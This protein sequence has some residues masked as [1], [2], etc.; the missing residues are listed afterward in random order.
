MKT[1]NQMF[2]TVCGLL[3]ILT[4]GTV[5][6][7]CASDGGT[8]ANDTD[9]ASV[10][11]TEVL[12]GRDADRDTLPADLNFDGRKFSIFVADYQQ[13]FVGPEEET[14]DIVDDAVLDR[15]RAVE[16]RLN[17]DLEYFVDENCKWDTIYQILNKYIMAGDTTFDVYT[18]QQFGITSLLINGGFV[19][20]YD[21]KYLD[22][23]QP[24]WNNRYMD[25][26]AIGNNT[27]YFLV[28]DFF[29]SPLLNTHVVYFNKTMY[30]QLHEDPEE[31]YDLALNGTWTMD[32]MAQVAKDAYVDVNNNGKTDVDDQLGF[33]AYQAFSTVDPFMYMTDVEFTP[34]DKDGNLTF[35]LYDERC[36]DLTTSIVEFFHQAGV[37]T[38][39]A[40]GESALVKAV[41]T[42]GSAQFVGCYR[43]GQSVNF[44]DMKDDFGM[45]P[46]P[47]MDVNQ[48]HYN[49]LVADIATLGAVPITSQNQDIAGA[50]IEALSSESY[51]TMIPVWYEDA[52]KIKYS[53]DDKTSQIIDIIHDASYTDFMYAYSPNLSNV[54]CLMRDLVNGNNTNY[55]SFVEKYENKVLDNLEK[56]IATYEEQN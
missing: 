54:G 36:V 53:R 18:G 11:T 19:N 28:S 22:F 31:L 23:D 25:E 9:T 48:E 27:R 40:T 32:K 44:R 47:K 30:G 49:C 21:L 3:A 55:I 12:T 43:L 45:L 46:Y 33:I 50:V 7:A 14:G 39:I 10:E 15:N 6:T 41:F 16:E 26:L 29:I 8:S 17:I 24:W 51:R 34:R 4:V 1:A 13:F 2:R 56:I 38:Q 35:N 20:A 42:E 52:L 5:M 37:Y